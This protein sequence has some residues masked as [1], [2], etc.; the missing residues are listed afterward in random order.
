MISPIEMWNCFT[1]S[2]TRRL[3]PVL[4]MVG[5]VAVGEGAHAQDAVIRG[6]VRDTLGQPIR[7]AEVRVL[8]SGPIALSRADGRYELREVTPG[9]HRLLARHVGFRPT[10]NGVTIGRDTMELD[11]DL[12]RVPQLLETQLISSRRER[13]P[14]VY[15]RLDKHLGVTMF[16]EELAQY[17]GQDV[18]DLF[19][20]VVPRFRSVLQAPARCGR[21]V[22][23]VDGVRT[24][25][26]VWE[27]TSPPPTIGDFVSV[28][29]IDAVEVF[30]SADFVDENFLVDDD[31]FAA[32]PGV[33][34]GST[35]RA[36]PPKPPGTGKSI[37]EG[38]ASAGSPGGRPAGGISGI[39]M[40]SPIPGSR[41]LTTTCRRIVLIWTKY[42]E[43]QRPNL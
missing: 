5:M 4:A 31:V 12:E 43:G 21:P 22:Y 9:D 38:S 20:K 29:D 11:I 2:T 42:F 25:P 8:P 14:R 40:G 35:R 23:F 10:L 17:S 26:V 16:A 32:D 24:P 7:G 34:S 30:R 27:K 19:D 13:L 3:I 6:V 18:T 39:Y 33:A 1:T 28:E 37:L 41:P 15:D 36:A